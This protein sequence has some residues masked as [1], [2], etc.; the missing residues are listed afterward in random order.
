[1]FL[2]LLYAI[3]VLLPL[4][5]EGMF[6]MIMF[7][8]LTLGRSS[9]LNQASSQLLGKYIRLEYDPDI[10]WHEEDCIICMDKFT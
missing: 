3:F 5:I 9:A 8:F 2:T 4:L 7:C 6:A 1:M 10:F